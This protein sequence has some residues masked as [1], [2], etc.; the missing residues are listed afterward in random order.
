MGVRGGDALQVMPIRVVR[1]GVTTHH[2][3]VAQGRPWAQQ[4]GLIQE[5]HGCATGRTQGLMKLQEVLP[6]V[7]LHRHAQGVR[8]LP[9]RLQERRG[10]GVHL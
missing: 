10:A 8:G 9:G 3:A 2:N 4:A 7:D 1:L 5:F 6:R